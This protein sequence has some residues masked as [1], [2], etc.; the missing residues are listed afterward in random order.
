MRHTGSDLHDMRSELTCTAWSEQPRLALRRTEMPAPGPGQVLVRVEA[1]AVN[2]IDVKRA[3]GYGRRLL[4]LKGAAR[5]P[6]VLGNDV[7]GV[8]QEIGQ[9]VS[10][11]AKD[12]AVFGLVGTGRSP[13][14]HASHVLLPQEQLVA[15]SRAASS[16]VLAVL[17]YSFTTM[18]LAVM[19]TGLRPSNAAGARVLVNGANGGLGRLALHLLK[20]WDSRV[21]AICAQGTREDCVALGAELAVERGPGLIES[22]PLDYHVVLNF[23]SWDDDP[24]LA[25]HLGADASGHATTVHPLLANFDRFGWL[26]GALASRRD[27]TRVR[28][29]V[30]KRAPRARYAW[31]VFKLDREALDALAESVRERGL[32]LPVGLA[33]PFQDAAAAFEHVTLGKAGRAVLLPAS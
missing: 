17:P 10:R 28:S 5:L 26:R 32:S 29:L 31:T 9:G 16:S 33:V 13:G 21:T 12:Q 19:S 3:A 24:L 8:V 23:G 15:A 11:F 18:W 25:P 4:G 1:A 2:P 14:A 6:V 7:A 30:A 22:L 27:W 20:T